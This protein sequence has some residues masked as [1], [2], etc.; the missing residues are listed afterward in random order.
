MKTKD[1]VI[2]ELQ[3]RIDQIDKL[4]ESA[5][6]CLTDGDFVQCAVRIQMLQELSIFSDFT[7]DIFEIFTSNA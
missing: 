6:E 4:S 1:V 3:N 2:R 7:M 5:K